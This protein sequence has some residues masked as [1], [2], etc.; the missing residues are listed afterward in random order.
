MGRRRSLKQDKKSPDKGKR[1]KQAESSKVDKVKTPVKET[2]QV[3]SVVTS[4]QTTFTEKVVGEAIRTIENSSSKR[5]QK[6]P[7]KSLS[8]TEKEKSVNS[9]E[10]ASVSVSENPN[11]DQIALTKDKAGT[12]K[13]IDGGFREEEEVEMIFEVPE[14][15]NLA[16]SVGK[17]R[18]LQNSSAK[19]TPA[20]KKH[21]SN[22]STLESK[23]DA[24]AE[25]M[26]QLMEELRQVKE[27]LQSKLKLSA[28]PVINEEIMLEGSQEILNNMQEVDEQAKLV[29]SPSDTTLYV[30]AV[31]KNTV[32]QGGVVRTLQDQ[33]Y[34]DKFVNQ[35]NLRGNKIMNAE[36]EKQ[37]TE[38]ANQEFSRNLTKFLSNLRTGAQ[39]NKEK[40][41]KPSTS[42]RRLDFDREDE[43]GTSMRDQAHQRI[44]EA[45]K[46]RLEM[47]PPK[48]RT[49][50]EFPDKPILDDDELMH[51]TC[52][53]D[54]TEAKMAQ[55]SQ[56]MDLDKLLVKFNKSFNHDE[57]QKLEICSKDG[58]LFYIP[59]E[60][61][62]SRINNFHMWEKAFR[63][64]MA[65][66]AQVHPTKVP[67][68]LQYIS[69]IQHAAS[70]YT[71]ENVA[72]YDNVFRHW[73]AKNPNRSWAK[74]LTQIWNLALCDPLSSVRQ[75]GQQQGKTGGKRDNKGTCWKFNKG[76][77]TGNCNYIH[78]CTYCGGTNHGAHVCF[79]K[80]RKSK[81]PGTGTGNGPVVPGISANG[82]GSG[83]S[84]AATNVGE[85]KQQKN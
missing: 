29:R 84:S 70:K 19:V 36:N 62:S 75:N 17:K 73:M 45:E 21:K 55:T 77:C 13:A 32:A 28:N 18:V 12:S 47:E 38:D 24:N 44:V 25:M 3:R 35:D 51:M 30:P 33:N 43:Q 56:F 8:V 64:Y 83:Q 16:F 65:L 61:K 6:T 2:Q 57:S 52:H 42:R 71:W 22:L 66:Y 68:M 78:R 14:D 1:S 4:K 69:T 10:N 46:H 15:E 59:K 53:V 76:I 41:D 48:G 80:A 74:S 26:Q 39:E 31:M 50:F 79:R 58:Q 34:Q 82:Q 72:H 63:I 37:K 60:E 27:Q 40:L 54:E 9:N 11:G 7:D 20:K 85:N 5:K 49:N 81:T 67:E 23:Q